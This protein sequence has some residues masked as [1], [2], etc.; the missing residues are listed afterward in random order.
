MYVYV[1]MCVCMYVCV[2]VCQMIEW[3]RNS[4]SPIAIDSIQNIMLC[5]WYW[6]L[7]IYKYSE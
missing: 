7:I 4:Q 6:A 2:C 1:S 3:A 5:H